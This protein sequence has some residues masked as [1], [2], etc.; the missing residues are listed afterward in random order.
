MLYTFNLLIATHHTI[1]DEDGVGV[2]AEK[3][4]HVLHL[5]MTAEAHHLVADGMLESK[6]N[7]YGNNHHSQPDGNTNSGDSDGRTAHLT[8]IA[9]ITI[10][11]LGYEKRKIHSSSTLPG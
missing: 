4:K 2:G 5:D 3:G 8:F 9:L 7:A 6:N 1:V 11:T 10:D